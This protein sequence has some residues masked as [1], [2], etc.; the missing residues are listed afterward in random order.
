MNAM[1]KMVASML[2]LTPEKMSE[3]VTGFQELLSTL[4]TRLE[5]IERNQRLI[6]D[7]LGVSINDGSNDSDSSASERSG[8][9]AAE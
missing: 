2:G 1:E 4:K 3:M 8:N 7:H 9:I 5:T 6:A